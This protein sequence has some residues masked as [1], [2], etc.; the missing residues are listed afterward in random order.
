MTIQQDIICPL[1]AIPVELPEV[2]APQGEVVDDVCEGFFAPVPTDA[3]DQLIARYQDEAANV[4][5]VGEFVQTHSYRSAL[6]HFLAGNAEGAVLVRR[7][8]GDLYSVEGAMGHL[9]G[10]YWR[11]LLEMT[12]VSDY[13]PYERKKEWESQINSGNAPA[14][15]EATV[16]STLQSMLVQRSTFFAERVDGVF[17][18]LSKTHIT[19]SPAG[20]TS[21]FIIDNAESK[22][23]YLS[24]LRVVISR[25][26]GQPETTVRNGYSLLR[27]LSKR[28]GVWHFVDGAALRIKMFKV[29]TAHVEVHPEIAARLNSLLALLHPAAIPS[30]FRTRPKLPPKEFPVLSRSLPQAV[31]SILSEPKTPG[32]VHYQR[33]T[34]N[35]HA[36]HF[37]SDSP[38]VEDAYQVLEALGGVRRNINRYVW[39]EF[40]YDPRPAIE[41]VA[42]SGL[43]PDD[44][45]HQFYPTREG[46]A[47]TAAALADI[48]E[49]HQCLEPSAGNGALAA[50]MPLERTTC[51]EISP[52]RCEVLNAKGYRTIEADFLVWA[53][54][55]YERFDRIILN[56]PFANNRA[57]LHLQAAAGLLRENGRLVAILPASLRG[58]DLLPGWDVKWHGPFENQFDGTNVQVSILV[59][60]RRPS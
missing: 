56:P 49:G 31:I 41:Q 13:M 17:R 28:P 1:Q 37:L 30:R 33:V 6:H 18:A 52:M 12:D 5:A 2:A 32:E 43:V 57:T 9:N 36:I 60:E 24:N 20:F 14:F 29:G 54:K 42:I 46:M 51:V 11:T 38:Y 48:Q 47:D 23:G 27:M 59:A 22:S 58:K 15:E 39:F 44:K 19:N 45:S 40:D 50:K 34:Q 53:E 3:V 16:R 21:R 8:N 25:F 35:P 55:T 10:F 26:M 4:R 7:V